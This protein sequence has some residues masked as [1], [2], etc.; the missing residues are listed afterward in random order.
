MGI[1]TLSLPLSLPLCGHARR[2][3]PCT[4]HPSTHFRFPPVP[5]SLSRSLLTRIVSHSPPSMDFVSLLLS[6]SRS[7][8]LLSLCRPLSTRFS[9]FL[10]PF[11]SRSLVAPPP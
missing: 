3:L 10:T 5:R 9:S 11:T 8:P 7:S 4:H 1:H 6:R 2:T